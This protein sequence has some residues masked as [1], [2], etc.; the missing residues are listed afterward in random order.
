[1]IR[2]SNTQTGNVLLNYIS[3]SS[4]V[5]SSTTTSD[6]EI[7]YTTSVLFLSLKFHAIKP[8]YIYQRINK[9]HLKNLNILIV[10]LDVPN[11]NIALRELFKNIT[12]TCI[13]CKTFQE[14]AYY[15]KGFDKATNKSVE[16]IR[17]K[18]TGIDVFF[19]SI[20]KINK[21]DC[22][23]LKKHFTNLQHVF[24]SNK[25]ELSEIQGIGLTKSE[26]MLKYF[27]MPFKK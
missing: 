8:D 21:T 9:M 18:S 27:K 3:V 22:I 16:Q 24:R 25:K 6:Y 11:F 19:E 5:Y 20:F 4:W 10:L 26:I 1:M 14:C 12:I 2:V 15:I 13:V 23:N 7:N 17:K